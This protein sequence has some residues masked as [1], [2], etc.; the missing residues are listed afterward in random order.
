MDAA[1]PAHAP[2]IRRLER[3][4][5]HG[6]RVIVAARSVV[7]L[8][9]VCGILVSAVD[10]GSKKD[11]KR[12][13]AERPSRER[14]E[15]APGLLRAPYL[16]GLARDSVLVVW[17][18]P[19][20]DAPQVDFGPTLEYGR[21]AEA[22]S[23]GTRRVAVLRGLK[24][25]SQFYYRVR[26]GS[27]VLAGGADCSFRTDRGP[28]RGAFAFF[29][30]GDIGSEGGEQAPTAASVLRA[31]P[32]PE[33]ALLTGDIVYKRGRSADYDP[34]LMHPWQD[35]LSQVCAW[36]ALGNHDWKSDPETNFRHEWY[37]PHNEHYYSFE[38]GDAHFIA[39]D[40][41]DGEIY[42]PDAQVHWL[43]QDLEAHRGADWT[44][45]YYHHPGIT[46]TYKGNE[47]S[48]IHRFLPLF[49]RYQVDVVF[50]GHAHTYERLFPLR[51]GV[52]VDTDQDPHYVDP[53]GTLYIVTG[54]GSQVKEG[55]P[56]RMCGPTAFF[57][58]ETI[59][60]TQVVVD[61]ARCTIRSIRSADDSLIDEVT[62]TKTR[63]AQQAP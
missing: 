30:T 19:G 49:D 50:N 41:R 16:Q 57:K 46:C 10:A 11:S 36:P 9:A 42:E 14:T 25:G 48:V 29:V 38:W 13:G 61:G 33:F 60:W 6:R 15:V 62:I 52:P 54:A 12:R 40:T 34:H 32:K 18:A 37:L 26:A 8:A 28:R 53:N 22:V 3:E 51:G 58:D 7:A 43:E 1:A 24:P 20:P 35:L 21:T 63:L 56:T 44:F 39:L 4:I 31:V 47:T 2:K 59:L 55:K 17:D 23:E 27:R 5:M 45:V